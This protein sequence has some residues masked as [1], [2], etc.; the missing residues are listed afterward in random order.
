MKEYIEESISAKK[1]FLEDEG[2]INALAEA[3]DAVHH[4]IASGSKLLIA[5]NGGSAADA[6]HFAGEFVGK[7]KHD[8]EA[9]PAI[10]LT[11]DTSIIT[12]W[13]N[14]HDF[15]SVFSRKLEALGSEGDVF[16]AI[17]TSGNSKNIFQALETAKNKGLKTISLLGR[18][19]GSAKGIADIDII[20]PSDNTPRI[21]EVH[22]LL[23][24]IISEEVERRLVEASKNG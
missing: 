20:I 22:I 14:D 9:Y 24:H 1:A 17:S 3:V 11:T 13:S 23:I 16:V 21:Q 4:S 5:G 15:D 18:G 2:L 7:Y 10:A 19:G 6:Q 8:R 12:A